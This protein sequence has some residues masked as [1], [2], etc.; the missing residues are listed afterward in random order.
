MDVKRRDVGYL[1]GFV[2]RSRGFDEV[3]CDSSARAKSSRTRTM[4]HQGPSTKE[5]G[6][7]TVIVS[8]TWV[9]IDRRAPAPSAEAP[10]SLAFLRRAD[11]AAFGV[12]NLHS[13]RKLVRRA[14]RTP[15][16]RPPTTPAFVSIHHLASSLY[17]RTF[18]WFPV[19][20][21]PRAQK[22]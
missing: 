21:N 6:H 11:A 19:F 1:G 15:T 17:T 9:G 7:P 13:I 14:R 22:H 12:G 5:Y 2:S 20:G 4:A 8:C 18:E 3:N 10:R 16:A